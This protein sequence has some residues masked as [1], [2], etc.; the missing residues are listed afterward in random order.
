MNFDGRLNIL[1]I[2]GVLCNLQRETVKDKRCSILFETVYHF[3]L[4]LFRSKSWR[5]VLR[6][7]SLVALLGCIFCGVPLIKQF[8]LSAIESARNSPFFSQTVNVFR[9]SADFHCCK[10]QWK[11]ESLFTSAVSHLS[12]FPGF[13][14]SS[15]FSP[16][17]C[18]RVYWKKPGAKR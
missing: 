15:I 10:T 17:G 12:I 18:L 5:S 2:F 4:V 11:E 7:I 3:V 13:S 1:I 6:E 8:T 16:V 14:F 9:R